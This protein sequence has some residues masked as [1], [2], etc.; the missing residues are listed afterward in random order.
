MMISGVEWAWLG[1]HRAR[2]FASRRALWGD[3]KGLAVFFGRSLF[4]GSFYW[5]AAFCGSAARRL[6]CHNPPEAAN[7]RLAIRWRFSWERAIS[8]AARIR[9]ALWRRP[10]SSKKS[11][12]R[13]LRWEIWHTTL[14][15]W[16]NFKI[17]MGARG[18]NSR[19]APGRRWGTTN[20]GSAALLLITNTGRGRPDRAAKVITAMSWA[21]G[22]WWC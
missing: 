20:T 21:L 1:W 14:L 9:R 10:S 13:C 2:L 22:T 8:L 19:I 3:G 7:P 16:D 6:R 17:A 4:G 12:G 11:L 15:P 5:P 18:V